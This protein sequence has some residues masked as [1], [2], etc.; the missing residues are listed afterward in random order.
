MA[1]TDFLSQVNPL[2]S[3][4][5]GL[6]GVGLGGL[7]ASLNQRKERRERFVLDQLREFYA[8][9]L[10]IWERLRA[11]N[12]VRLKVSAAANKEWP[13]LM[14]EARESGTLQ[15]VREELS[16]QFEK[17]IEYENQQLIEVDIPLYGQMVELFTAKMHLAEP[18]T[19]T[20]FPA[21]V[22]FVE[23]WN[24]SLRRAL[25]REVAQRVGVG[26]NEDTLI[27]LYTD[28]TVNLERLTASLKPTRWC[29]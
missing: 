26:A 4:A 22:E 14:N 13:R 3:A 19:R 29:E 16:P 25:P 7:L 28:L 5:A 1:G 11:K 21:L 2:I 24:R 6:L 8:P 18:S 17:I 12:Q 9:M 20:H 10:G 23:M 15:E 27:P